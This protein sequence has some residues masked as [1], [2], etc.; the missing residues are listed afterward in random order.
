MSSRKQRCNHAVQFATLELRRYA[1]VA[2]LGN[3]LSAT[4]ARRITVKP[5]G[6]ANRQLSL[7]QFLF[8]VMIST[9]CRAICFSTTVFLAAVGPVASA[10]TPASTI[11]ASV[12]PAAS[13]LFNYDQSAPLQIT[14]IA[15][16]IRGD[17][18]VRDL[19]FV[20]F[21]TSR[22]AYLVSPAGGGDS[23]AA[24]LYVHWLGDRA[25]TNRTEFLNEA[26]ALANQGIVSLLVD[27]MWA[28]PKW[29]DQRVPENDYAHAIKQVIELRR[30]LDL[31]LSQPGI[32][33]SRLAL[34]GHDFGAMYGAVMGAVDRRPSTYV[35]MASTAHF[36]D[37]FMFAQQPKSPEDYRKQLAPLDPILF[38]PQLG[39]A[40]VFF[41]F[42][43]HDKYVSTDT[44]SRLFEAAVPRKQS[45]MYDA[46]HS[47]QKPEVTADRINWLVRALAKKS[48]NDR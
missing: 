44:A 40:P 33:S 18:R 37:W 16:E 21:K 8:A 32:D 3:W 4:L 13:S 2:G 30:A 20:P 19:T 9:R 25:T 42:A 22:K 28:E 29:Y 45:A 14:N 12:T 39:P 1:T 38:V 10:E 41:Q 24:I 26:V 35:L 5:L 47:L 43:A 34:V 23:L 7:L 15:E 27:T 31:L 17:A 46:N 11:P 36:I 6:S 48:S